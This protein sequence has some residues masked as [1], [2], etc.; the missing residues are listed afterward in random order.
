MKDLEA[1]NKVP[2]GFYFDKNEW[3]MVTVNGREGVLPGGKDARYFR[4]P[5][6]LAVGA[7]PLIGA[8][9]V[10]FLPFIGFALFAKH[11]VGKAKEKAAVDIPAAEKARRIS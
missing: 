5:S 4:V 2:G 11:L 9:F 3:K 6:L 1:G 10:L 8:A 7:S